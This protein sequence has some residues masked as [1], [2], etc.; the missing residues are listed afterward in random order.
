MPKL[1]RGW[2]S[3]RPPVMDAWAPSREG[4]AATVGRS[5]PPPAKMS[6]Y[7]PGQDPLDAYVHRRSLD[8]PER[9]LQIPLRSR[10]LAR[11]RCPLWLRDSG[12][13]GSRAL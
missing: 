9:F 1:D 3:F 13:H 7:T 12:A 11:R 8:S 10:R 2:L 6:P 4:P 5:G